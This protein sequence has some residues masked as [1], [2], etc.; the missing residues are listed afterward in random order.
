MCVRPGEPKCL[1]WTDGRTILGTDEP[2][3]ISSGAL[4]P[5]PQPHEHRRGVT[6]PCGQRF[7]VVVSCP[8]VAPRYPEPSYDSVVEAWFDSMADLE[9]LFFSDDFLRIVDPDHENLGTFGRIV[10]EEEVVVSSGPR[11]GTPWPAT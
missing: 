7:Q 9:A 6:E 1:L 2:S 8:V 3:R 4:A 11:P 10:S 5:L